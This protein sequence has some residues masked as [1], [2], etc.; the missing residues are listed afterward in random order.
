MTTSRTPSRR[1]TQRRIA[2]L[3]GVSQA[4]VSLVLNDKADGAARI[5]EETRERVLQGASRETGYVA[6]PVARRLAGVG[7]RILGVFTYEPA[8]PT[9]SQRLLPA[10]PAAASSR[11]PRSSAAT[12]CC[13]R[14]RPWWTAR[15]GSSTSTTGCGWPTDASCSVVEMDRAELSSLV[16]DGFPFV[17]V[18][19]RDVRRACPTSAPTTRAAPP[20]WSAGRGRSAT[21]ASPTSTSTAA[22]SRCSTAARGF[23]G[24]LERRGG[25]SAVAARCSTIPSLGDD[26][27][28]DWAAIR[29]SGATVVVVEDAPD[30]R[31]ACTSSPR[32]RAS[33][34]PRRLSMIV[35][36]RARPRAEA[37][38][39][40]TRL[41]PP[42]TAARERR[43]E[44][45]GAHPRP[46]RRR[47]RPTTCGRRCRAR[48]SPA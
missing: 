5:P 1:I 4:T 48:P 23:V 11:R 26:L 15:G 36:S 21:G 32:A 44:P 34:C 2:E 40:F 16:A 33:R 10:V 45:P 30:G 14:A 7:N 24:E 27:E 41:R 13:S 29:A 9:E 37:P 22:A 12:C 31:R 18:G 38:V 42:R 46:R 20:T 28:R 3:A 39:E 35:L 47:A 17:A 8:F 6:D 43:D 25:A 19:R